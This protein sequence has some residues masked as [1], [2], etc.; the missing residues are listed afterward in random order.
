MDG[1]WLVVWR[2][3]VAGGAQVKVGPEE[4]LGGESMAAVE[5]SATAFIGVG[6]QGRG[7][8]RTMWPPSRDACV[9]GRVRSDA[10]AVVEGCQGLDTEG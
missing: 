4:L 2:W 10:G 9:P 3:E 5:A 7:R 8:R 6:P 1:H